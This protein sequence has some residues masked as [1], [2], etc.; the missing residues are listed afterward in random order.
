MKRRGGSNLW[1]ASWLA[2]VTVGSFVVG[3]RVGRD[4][5]LTAFEWADVGVL[6]AVVLAM[7]ALVLRELLRP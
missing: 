5:V 6:A 7:G 4:A 2:G 3:L 1:P